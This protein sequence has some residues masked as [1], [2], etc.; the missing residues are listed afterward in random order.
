[1]NDT[2]PAHPWWRKPLDMFAASRLGS[3]LFRPTLHHIDR[4]LLWLTRG[5]AG[6]TLGIPTL[7]LTTTGAR[8]GKQ[9]TVPLLYV[10]HGEDVVVIGTRFG[11]TTHPGW[12]YNL[13]NEPRASVRVKGERYPVTARPATAEEREQ[14]WPQAV[15][16]YPGYDTYLDRVGNREVPI[17]VLARTA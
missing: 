4:V 16:I 11:S 7:Q 14:I 17:F 6:M 5:H 12:Y 8:S 15:R 10:R 9:L 1:M 2:N 3:A 13:R